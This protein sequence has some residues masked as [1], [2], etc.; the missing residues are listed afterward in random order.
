MVKLFLVRGRQTSFLSEH[1]CGDSP[2]PRPKPGNK[3]EKAQS[4]DVDMR[5]GRLSCVIPQQKKT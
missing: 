4:Q 3:A 5:L 2:Q 1:R